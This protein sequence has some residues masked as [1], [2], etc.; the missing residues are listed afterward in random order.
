VAV[1]FA[2]AIGLLIALAL[3]GAATAIAVAA[4]RGRASM[5][6]PARAEFR[7]GIGSSVWIPAR[8]APLARALA[9]RAPPA[10]SL[11]S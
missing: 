8:S 4:A 11:G 3:R 9:P 2:L 5:A 6:A 10:P 1:P 7:S